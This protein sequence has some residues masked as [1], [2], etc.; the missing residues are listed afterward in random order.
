MRGEHSLPF[1]EEERLRLQPSVA[2]RWAAEIMI[3][4]VVIIFDKDIR[5]YKLVRIKHTSK[6]KEFHAKGHGFRLKLPYPA[7]RGRGE[8]QA[9]SRR[10]QQTAAE[11]AAKMLQNNNH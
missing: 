1:Q 4:T 9:S 10:S 5:S 7:G 8:R 11:D 2:V 3:F 6:R